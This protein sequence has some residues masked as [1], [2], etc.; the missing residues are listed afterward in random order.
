MITRDYINSSL[1][2]YQSGSI[3]FIPNSRLRRRR[4]KT[5][6]YGVLNTSGQDNL[7]MTPLDQEDDEED[8]TVF[9]VNGHRK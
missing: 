1:H 9:E 5:R 3:Y 2:L 8:M 7:E 6:R 4:S